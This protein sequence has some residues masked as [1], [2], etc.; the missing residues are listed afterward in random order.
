[1]ALNMKKLNCD[2]FQATI[3]F[4]EKQFNKKDFLED[5]KADK[6][7]KFFVYNYGTKN[8][9]NEEHAHLV[10]DLDGK[11]SSAR[12]TYHTGQNA[13][14]DDREPYLENFAQWLG[15]FFK[16]K[17][18]TVEISIICVFSKDDF[19]V[20][21]PL[22]F[23]VM[24][25]DNLM[26]GV[27]VSGYELD[28][29]DKSEIKRMIVSEKSNVFLSVLN[30]SISTNFTEFEIYSQMEKFSEYAEPFINKRVRNEN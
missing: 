7:E 3:E 10:L 8:K 9:D 13:N 1:M 23:P 29:P 28:F 12:L 26:K 11:D 27:K 6:K 4:D 19:D 16:K 25:K 15:R 14:E 5:V 20:T 17:K 24:V 21:I 22:G 30:A 18:L 2:M